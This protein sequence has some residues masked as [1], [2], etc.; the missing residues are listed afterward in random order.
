[1]RTN[2][3]NYTKIKLERYLEKIPSGNLNQTSFET[4][5]YKLL[6]LLFAYKRHQN[7]LHLRWQRAK[8]NQLA[9]ITIQELKDKKKSDLFLNG[10]YD[11]LLLMADGNDA[12]VQKLLE[13][14]A[15][16]TNEISSSQSKKAG[17]IRRLNP[18]LQRAVVHL[19]RNVGITPAE[20]IDRLKDDVGEYGIVEFGD[21]IFIYNDPVDS[22]IEKSMAVNSVRNAIS[23]IKKGSRKYKP[24]S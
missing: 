17:T 23:R 10:I 9:L 16:R 18:L 5:G 21:D 13:T 20:I 7:N 2:H 3:A 19:K 6:S 8:S 22:D 14:A 12:M 1:M 4:Y 15:I 24:S 11:A